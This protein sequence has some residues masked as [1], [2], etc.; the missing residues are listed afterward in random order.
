MARRFTLDAPRR[1]DN[2]AL[3]I[4]NRGDIVIPEP[5]VRLA[6]QVAA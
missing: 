5:T 3:G 6:F 4:N 1:I 2:I